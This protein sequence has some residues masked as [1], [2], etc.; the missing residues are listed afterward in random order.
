MKILFVID[1]LQHG[2]AERVASVLCNYFARENDVIIMTTASC[3][4]DYAIDKKIKIISTDCNK[5]RLKENL[6][7]KNTRRVTSII[8]VLGKQ[9]VDVIVAFMGEPIVRAVI[10]GK[11]KRVPI[12][13]SLRNDP[14]N[15]F[16][17]IAGKIKQYFLKKADY[18]VFQ[19]NE[20]MEYYGKEIQKKSTVIPNPID[21]NYLCKYE[22]KQRKK[23]IL[24]VGRLEM[25]KN[26]KLLIE[27]FSETNKRIRNEYELHFYGDGSL[28][29][30]LNKY[31]KDMNL[32]EKIHIYK[33]TK[34]IKEK[35][36][37]ADMFVLS[38]I[39]EG[40]PNTLMEA[41]ASGCT[42]ISSDC[43]C[44]GAR[45]L[46]TNTKDGFLFSNG[47][48]KELVDLIEKII[49]MKDSEKEIIRKR[50]A[51]KMCGYSPNIICRQ[52]YD[53]LLKVVKEKKNG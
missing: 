3:E 53:V 47:N 15:S 45:A 5:K 7:Q 42:V 18:I 51:N 29:C 31:I 24:N 41:M 32:S 25:Q 46:I 6:I 21:E 30:E 22:K 43:P 34:R 17:G 10:A 33:R 2:G 38:S 27:A 35:M 23:I 12:V 1:S 52:W 20:A 40:M 19:T 14:S 48:K 44:G 50:A 11:I 9:E 8:K 28:E 39:Y 49:K 36:E 26:Q 4:S 37:E 13:A 16:N